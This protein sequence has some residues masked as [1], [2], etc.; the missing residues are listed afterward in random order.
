MVDNQ[1]Q[2]WIDGQKVADGRWSGK[3]E[4]GTHRIEC[5]KDGHRFTQRILEVTPHTVG[6]ITLE[7]PTP[8][9]GAVYVTS[10]PLGSDIYVDDELVGK[11]P[12]TV[13]PLIGTR[14]I[15]VSH[16]GYKSETRMIQVSET[17]SSQLD[18]ELTDIIDVTIKSN[19]YATLFVDGREVGKTP[20]KGSL[21]S[22][23]HI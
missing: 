7:A 9:Y 8:V 13:N 15:T 19:P 16:E 22:L 3:L 17:E 2:I 10:S 11:T 4:Y 14:R 1:A 6:T 12:C 20:W 21:L 18:V 23:I 5:K